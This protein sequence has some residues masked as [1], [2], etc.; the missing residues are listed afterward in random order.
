[1]EQKKKVSLR[2]A[3]HALGNCH[4]LSVL[5]PGF[6]TKIL[7]DILKQEALSAESKKSLEKALQDLKNLEVTGKEADAL[8]KCIKTVVY[9]RVNPDEIFIETEKGASD[10]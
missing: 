2:K 10:D 6:I 7:E 1:M 8:L 4:H 5:I 9:G 3:L